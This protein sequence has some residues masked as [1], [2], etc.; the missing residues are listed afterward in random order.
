MSRLVSDMAE[1]VQ[2]SHAH[3]PPGL[4]AEKIFPHLTDHEI[5]EV[6][7]LDEKGCSWKFVCTREGLVY[8][9]YKTETFGKTNKIAA[10]D[11]LIFTPYEGS[12]TLHVAIHRDLRPS[13]RRAAHVL[14]GS[15]QHGSSHGHSHAFGS[16][17]KL[18]V[19]VNQTTARA[20]SAAMPRSALSTITKGLNVCAQQGHMPVNPLVPFSCEQ[21]VTPV[22]HVN[23]QTGV[24]RRRWVEPVAKSA[25]A[26]PLEGT[27]P[28]AA[29]LPATSAAPTELYQQHGRRYVLDLTSPLAGLGMYNLQL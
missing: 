26:T 13:W 23:P 19:A 10:G 12:A 1:R 17:H 22:T 24:P 5:R 18:S 21:Y 9:L 14:S 27:T 28:L 7:C 2:V 16:Q 25:N 11:S 29:P 20:P 6:I 4:T 3:A 8:K 15:N